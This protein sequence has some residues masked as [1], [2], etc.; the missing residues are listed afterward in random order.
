MGHME[1]L[2]MAVSSP[3]SE[4]QGCAYASLTSAQR[5]GHGWLG[6]SCSLLERNTSCNLPLP[7]DGPTD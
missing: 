6:S 4:Q 1:D 2:M 7:D 5:S 3:N